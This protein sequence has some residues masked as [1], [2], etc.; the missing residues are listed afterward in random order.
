MY[1][2]EYIYIY[3][4]S[5]YILQP[6]PFPRFVRGILSV[7]EGVSPRVVHL[8]WSTRHTCHAISGRVLLLNWLVTP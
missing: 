1:I 5:C 8:G 6:F 4:T 7:S 2:Y 3:A